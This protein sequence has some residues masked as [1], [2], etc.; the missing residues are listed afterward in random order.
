MMRVTFPF[1]LW[2]LLVI[3]VSGQL[4]TAQGGS[5]GAR[6]VGQP[7]R[8]EPITL[9]RDETSRGAFLPAVRPGYASLQGIVQN[10]RGEL[11]PHA[12]VVLLRSLMT[13]QVVAETKVD[14]IATFTVRAFAP[15]SYMAELVDPHTRAMIATSESFT[16]GIGAIVRIAPI[17]PGDTVAGVAQLLQ[18]TSLATANVVNSAISAGVLAVESG[19]PV[20]P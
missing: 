19:V 1:T 20:S 10:H 3:L 9:T 11:V 17:V 13:G 5:S 7:I 18:T 2:L 14:E 4:L 8:L 16:A 6:L 12:G 15:G